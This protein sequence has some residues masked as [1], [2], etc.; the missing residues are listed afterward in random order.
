MFRKKVFFVTVRRLWLLVALL[1]FVLIILWV[2]LLGI[3]LGKPSGAKAGGR[4]AIVIDDF[5]LQRQ[6]VSEMLALDCKLTAAVMP[7]LAYSEDDAEDA[8]ESGK[9]VIIH[10]PMQSNYCGVASYL[11][12]RPVTVS[13]S[14]QELKKWIDDATSEL[15]EAKGANIH[16][17]SL[18]STR[19]EIMGP[20][21]SHLKEKGLF[22]LDSKTS[23]RSVCRKV[24]KETGVMFF[25][26]RVFLEHEMKSKD[27]VKKCLK[28]AMEIAKEEGRCIAIG[29]VGCEGGLITAEAIREM[30]PEIKNAGIE[31]V[32][33][34]ELKGN[35]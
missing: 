4:L 10:I 8:L 7:F 3:S 12:P 34:S 1:G 14:E 21:M 33:L 19:V 15:P 29:H 23:G 9:E 5:G 2:A 17:G 24:A 6:G 13:M 22:F 27:Y 26:N 16:M 32:F 31:L 30:L 28:K 35:V 20:I 25:E 18:C 11:G